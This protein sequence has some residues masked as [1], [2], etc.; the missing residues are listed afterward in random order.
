MQLWS[1]LLA[2]FARENYDAKEMNE[3]RGKFSSA[4]D[5]ER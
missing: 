3:K 1:L 4:A 5:E 2:L